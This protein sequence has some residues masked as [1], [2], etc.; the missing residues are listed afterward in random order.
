MIELAGEREYGHFH[1]FVISAFSQVFY[2]QLFSSTGVVSPV[3]PIDKMLCVEV[4]VES[5]M[6]RTKRSALLSNIDVDATCV[7]PVATCGGH[8]CSY[9]TDV[10]VNPHHPNA[11]K[12]IFFSCIPWF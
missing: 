7:N 9:C 5:L 10:D 4:N 1:Q 11:F 3:K 8:S 12:K 2:C 6:R